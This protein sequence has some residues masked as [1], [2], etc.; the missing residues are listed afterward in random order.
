[1]PDRETTIA[2]LELNIRWIEDFPQHQ[3][4]GWGNVTM[5]M[6]DAAELLKAQEPIEPALNR[7]MAEKISEWLEDSDPGQEYGTTWACR[8]CMHSIHKPYIW[9]PYDSKIDYC[10]FCGARMER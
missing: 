5:A 4:P 2:N 3:F 7:Q 8:K 6:R 1:M 10:P 9:N